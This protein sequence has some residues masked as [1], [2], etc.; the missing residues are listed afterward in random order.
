MGWEQ[1]TMYDRIGHRRPPGD[2]FLHGLYGCVID[3]GKSFFTNDPQSHPDSIGLPQGHPELT[4]FLGVPLIL[5]GKTVGMLAVANRKGGYSHEQQEDLEA[6]APAVTQALQRKK[7][8]ETLAKI[9]IARQKE[10]HHRIKNNLQV[11]SSLLD[12]TAERF[13]NR[14]CIK[15]FEVLKAFRES[16]DRVISMALIHEELYKGEGFETLNFSQYIKELAENLL[17]TYSVGDKDII[18]NM[19]LEENALFDMD[20]AVPLGIIVNELLSNSLKHAFPDIKE[21]EILVELR[22][23]ENGECTK[24]INEDCKITNFVL[25]VSDNG[26][27]IPEDFYIENLDTLGMQL[28]TSLVDQLDGELEMKRENGTEFTVRFTVTEKD[29]QASA[30]ATQQSIEYYGLNKE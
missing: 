25:T 7:A 23:E 28:V 22:K 3:T 5:G 24:S 11:I 12:L 1:C 30:P 16:Q 21:G 4:S 9:D 8:E 20:T 13:N 10:I 14:E 2:F 6:I 27:G 26:V 29:N 18:L 19:Y 15:D 17:R